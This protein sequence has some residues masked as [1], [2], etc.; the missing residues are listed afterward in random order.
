MPG[1]GSGK[2]M[3]GMFRGTSTDCWKQTY[4]YALHQERCLKPQGLFITATDHRVL[5]LISPEPDPSQAWGPT[6]PSRNF[7][8][9]RHL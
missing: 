1:S 6:K 3:I 9:S 7:P 8:R 4:K 5:P 2:Y